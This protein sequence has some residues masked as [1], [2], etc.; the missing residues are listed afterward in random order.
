[1]NSLVKFVHFFELALVPRRTKVFP[2]LYSG[3]LLMLVWQD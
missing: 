1:M 3:Q 2:H